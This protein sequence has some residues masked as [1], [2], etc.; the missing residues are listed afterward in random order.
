MSIERDSK[1]IAELLGEDGLANLVSSLAA[2]F[3][4]FDYF[5]GEAKTVYLSSAIKDLLGFT[6]DIPVKSSVAGFDY[7]VH[8]DDMRFIRRDMEERPRGLGEIY[9]IDVRLLAGNGLYHW[10][11]VRAVLAKIENGHEIWNGIYTDIAARKESELGLTRMYQTINGAYAIVEYDQRSGY[12]VLFTTEDLSRAS[13]NTLAGPDEKAAGDIFLRAHPNDMA[14]MR[15]VFD[16]AI[17]TG[18]RIEKLFRMKRPSGEYLWVK[19]NLNVAEGEAGKT[20]IYGT[21]TNITELVKTHLQVE[22]ERER[23]RS[24]IEQ[25]NI[26]VLD[27][28]HKTGR[29]YLSDGLKAYSFYAVAEGLISKQSSDISVVHPDDRPLL[30]EFLTK[31]RSNEPEAACTLRA[32]M[33]DGSYRWTQISGSIKRDESGALLRSIGTFIDMDDERCLEAEMQMNLRRLETVIEDTNA[34]YWEYDIIS[35]VAYIG[36][37]VRKAYTLPP[38]MEN[39]PESLIKT[40]I[41]PDDYIADYRKLH[42]NLKNGALFGEVKL[43]MNSPGGTVRWKHIR[44]RTIF[45]ADSK[46]SRAIGTAIDITAQVAAETK[47]KIFKRAQKQK[48]DAAK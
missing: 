25:S 27:W 47:L 42:I 17:K 4:I 30:E 33:T 9:D 29:H 35:D 22:E 10:F 26:A 34:Q 48:T 13:E 38:V 23:L 18:K 45:N 12:K 16:E 21:F 32:K 7:Y 2:G 41:I 43:P 6:K 46:P 39:Y 28:D 36:D 8:P 3:G 37:I 24:L 19:P 5:E 15:E 31:I 44:Y 40:G 11:N 20:L 1:K 14:A